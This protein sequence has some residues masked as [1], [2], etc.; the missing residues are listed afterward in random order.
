[1]KKDAEL[2]A[3]NEREFKLAEAK[4]KNENRLK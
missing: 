1:M 4:K 2:K 3:K